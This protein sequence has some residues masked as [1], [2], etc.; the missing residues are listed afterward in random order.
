MDLSFARF[1]AFANAEERTIGKSTQK[2]SM[3]IS[4]NNRKLLR[5]L[6]QAEDGNFNYSKQARATTTPPPS[7]ALHSLSETTASPASSNTPA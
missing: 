3:H 5:I 6:P 1:V 7:S 4:K 2:C